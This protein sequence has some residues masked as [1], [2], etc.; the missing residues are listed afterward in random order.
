VLAAVE[1]VVIVATVAL[2]LIS[3]VIPLTVPVVAEEVA[4]LPIRTPGPVEAEAESVF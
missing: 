1:P 3:V 4:G 2:E